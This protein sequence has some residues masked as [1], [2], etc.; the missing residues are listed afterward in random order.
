MAKKATTKPAKKTRTVKEAKASYDAAP[1]QAVVHMS[2]VVIASQIAELPAEAQE[3]AAEFVL[4]LR[5]RYVDMRLVEAP[6]AAPTDWTERDTFGIW[7]DRPEMEDSVAYVRDLRGH[8]NI[9]ASASADRTDI[10][11]SGAYSLKLRRSIEN[12]EDGNL[13][14]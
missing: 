1:T 8:R 9:L 3:L 11:D 7:A 13:S 2:P 6:K 10:T 12:R 5:R 14:D 4:M